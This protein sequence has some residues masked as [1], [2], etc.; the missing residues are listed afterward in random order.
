MGEYAIA[1]IYDIVLYPFVHKLRHR[2]LELCIEQNYDSILDVC[3]GTGRQLKML[4]RQGF[5]VRGVDLSEEM[6]RVS[7]KGPY[8]PDCLNED[9]TQMSFDSDSFHAAMT[10]FALHEKPF[11][12][13]RSILEEMLRVVRPG[14]HLILT[15]FD[16]NAQSSRFSKAIIRVFEWNA[17]GEHYQNFKEFIRFGGISKLMEGLPAEF[18]EKRVAG[19]KSLAILIYRV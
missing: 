16:F 13:A 5:S 14:G 2:L 11:E 17:G 10:T 3:C 18:M 12:T 6:L 9:A 1:P 7:Q 19:L 8:A 15:D 4:Q